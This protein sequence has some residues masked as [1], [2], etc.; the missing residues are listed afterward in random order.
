MP[1]FN[2]QVPQANPEEFLRYS[3]GTHTIPVDKST[4]I[5]LDTAGNA[6]SG[7]ASL[8]DQIV[9]QTIS[10]D[11]QKGVDQQQSQFTGQLEN[12][13]KSMG[14]ST[15]NQG[16]DILP[17]GDQTQ[18]IPAGI[19]NG[20]N[21]INSLSNGITNGAGNKINDTLYSANITSIAKQLRAQY[22]GYRDYID[23]E[24]SKVSGM[25]VANAYYKNLMQDINS[26]LQN[27]KS[28]MEKPINQLASAAA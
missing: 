16:M 6:I 26:G 23:T 18:N 22:P 10:S 27:Q 5:L 8:A 9:K 11:I 19:T 24:I 4:G 28:L 7:V 3:Q 14:I 13:A 25:P 21:R 20:L 15:G 12:T 2:P 17:T 1:T